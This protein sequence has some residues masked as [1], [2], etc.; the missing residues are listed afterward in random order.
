MVWRENIDS[1]YPN[2]QLDTGSSG[3]LRNLDYLLIRRTLTPLTYSKG[4]GRQ[5]VVTTSH[6]QTEVAA[7]R[8]LNRHLLFVCRFHRNEESQS[9]DLA[10]RLGLTS[11]HR[12]PKVLL[13]NAGTHRPTRAKS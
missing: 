12:L 13:G 5:G 3:S 2:S 7:K 1:G 11:R 6:R 8:V 4:A 9:T 10:S